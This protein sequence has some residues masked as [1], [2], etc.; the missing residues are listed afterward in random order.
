[1]TY[2]NLF[3]RADRPELVC[4]VPEHRPVPNF[5]GDPPWTFVGRVKDRAIGSL[6]FDHEAAEVSVHYNGFYLFQLI[7][8][9]DLQLCVDKDKAKGALDEVTAH[10]K[11]RYREPPTVSW[12]LLAEIDQSSCRT[13][14]RARVSQGM[15][16]SV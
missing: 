12:R 5:I 2:Y 6:R 7:N 13:P 14:T 1:M 15:E 4:A 16:I 3:S 8:A 9:S 10:S 11:Q